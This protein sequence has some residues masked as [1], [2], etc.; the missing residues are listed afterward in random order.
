MHVEAL[1]SSKVEWLSLRH[2]SNAV[3]NNELTNK[4]RIVSAD[5]N[6]P[7]ATSDRCKKTYSILVNPPHYSQV[8]PIH[9]RGPSMTSATMVKQ[10]GATDDPQVEVRNPHKELELCYHNSNQ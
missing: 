9:E 4:E 5:S 6:N 2:T 1:Q 3:S 7:S 8:A 10:A